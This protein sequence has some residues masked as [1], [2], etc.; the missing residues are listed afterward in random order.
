MDIQFIEWGVSFHGRLHQS[1]LAPFSLIITSPPKA[2]PPGEKNLRA[3][4]ILA[5]FDNNRLVG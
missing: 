4:G 5:K 3:R 1:C 2:I